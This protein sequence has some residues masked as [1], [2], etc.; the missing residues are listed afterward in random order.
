MKIKQEIKPEDLDVIRKATLTD[1]GFL[2][3]EM[4]GMKDWG[5]IHDELA[6]FLRTSGRRKHIELARGHLKSSIVTKGWTIQQVL[7]NPNIRVLLANAVWDNSRKFL[8]SI[9]KYVGP[10][11]LIESYF[12][13]LQSEHWNQDECTVLQRTEI[14][15]APTWATT[16]IEKEQTSQHYDLIIADDLVARENVMTPEQREKVYLYYKDLNDLLE[17]DGTMVV[18]GTRWHQDDLY[19]KL[20]EENKTAEEHAGKGPWDMFIRTAYRED[21]SVTFPEK[22]SLEYLDQLRAAKGPYEFSAQYL[23]NPIDESAADFKK[24]WIKKYEP[25]TP[26]PASLYLTVDPALSLSRDADPSAGIVAGQFGNRII[27]VVDY[28]HKRLM[29]NELVDA[30]FQIVEKWHLRRIG[31]ESFAFQKTLKYDIQAEQRRRNHFFSIDE[32]GS[33]RGGKEPLLTKEARIRRLQPYFEQGLVEIRSDMKELE[34][35]LLSFPRGRH[36]DLIDALSYQLDYL[37][38]SVGRVAQ[39]AVIPGS[40]ADIVKIHLSKQV[41]SVYQRYLADLKDEPQ[42]PRLS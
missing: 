28:F 17:P 14:L 3:R 26:H 34:L 33:R 29:P 24:A 5:K 10:G 9:E 42:M 1:L 4:L 22:F 32:L 37:I 35:E 36:D 11:S 38:P 30:I 19:D 16:G 21:G 2:C 27:R 8:R 31:I 13:R 40:Y 41:G 6:L 7:G 12:G 23:N 15:D 18:I 20:I 39:K 25:G